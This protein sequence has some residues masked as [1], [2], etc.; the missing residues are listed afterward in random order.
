M[1]T[2]IPNLIT[3]RTA[4]L[5][6]DYDPQPVT[7]EEI[8]RKVGFCPGGVAPVALVLGAV[9]EALEAVAPPNHATAGLPAGAVPEYRFHRQRRWRFDY[10][11][12]A[13]R[14]ALEI[15]GGL[16]GRGKKCPTCGRRSVAGHSSIERLKTDLE[17]YN[18]AGLAGWLVLRVTPQQVSSG[19]AG[20]L[21]RLAL[22]IRR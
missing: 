7:D 11:W 21:V 5:P 16:Y 12:P 14:I 9:Q 19:E 10:A 2:R 3:G 13:R 8:R 15:E 17:K 22:A 18:A 20:R 4:R 1:P 6:G